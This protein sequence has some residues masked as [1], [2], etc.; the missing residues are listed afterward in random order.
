M[1]HILGSR[2]ALSQKAMW[3]LRSRSY[4]SVVSGQ[5]SRDGTCRGQLGCEAYERFVGLPY[6]VGDGA[7]CDEA[8]IIPILR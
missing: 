8:S 2:D 5:R 7:A 1:E 6:Y 3:D 4:Q